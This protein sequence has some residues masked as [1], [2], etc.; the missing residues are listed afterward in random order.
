[1]HFSPKA[2]AASAHRNYGS[3]QNKEECGHL[4][5]CPLLGRNTSED[6]LSLIHTTWTRFQC[7]KDDAVEGQADTKKCTEI[8][9]SG[10][11]VGQKVCPPSLSKGGNF[12]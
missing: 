9:R 12:P 6:T 1:M 10:F 5:S 8:Q 7:L 3:V 2:S 4:I 11:H